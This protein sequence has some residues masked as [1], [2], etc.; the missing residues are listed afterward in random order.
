MTDKKWSDPKSQPPISDEEKI[1]T[2]DGLIKR[3]P[4]YKNM[5]LNIRKTYEQNLSSS[6][7]GVKQ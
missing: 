2:I 3:H 6:F 5:L 4:Q 1:R 7:P